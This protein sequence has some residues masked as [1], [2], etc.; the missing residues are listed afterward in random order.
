MKLSEYAEGWHAGFKAGC[1]FAA[2][3]VIAA[4]VLYLALTW[5]A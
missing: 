3:A 1:L 2:G 5:S 4:T